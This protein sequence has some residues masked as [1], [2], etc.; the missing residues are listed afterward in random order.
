MLREIFPFR[1]AP[2]TFWFINSTVLVMGPLLVVANALAIL[3]D[4][5]LPWWLRVSATIAA[6]VFVTR[7]RVVD[8]NHVRITK[9]WLCLPY[10]HRLHPVEKV[11]A[12]YDPDETDEPNEIYLV[13][14]DDS[15][16]E[17]RCLPATRVADRLRAALIR[18]ALP[19]AKV[20]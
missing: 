3:V 14:R 6:C 9:L 15:Y 13:A 17:I 5:P 20:R 7:I 19:K 16:V 11:Q 1:R 8:A 4:L 18:E 10:R 12:S 2:R